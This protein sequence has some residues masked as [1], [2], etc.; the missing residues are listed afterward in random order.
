MSKR[1]FMAVILTII[2]VSGSVAQKKNADYADLKSKIQKIENDVT[3]IRRDQLNYKIEK[4]LLKEAFSSNLQTINT[5][6]VIVF[7]IFTVVGFLG[8]RDIG[9]LK[10]EYSQELEKLNRLGDDLEQKIKKIVQ[11]QE[12]D[13]S[14]YLKILNTNEEQNRRLKVLELQ[15][16]ISTLVQNRNYRMALEYIT[17][18]LDMD[19]TNLNVL[20]QKSYAQIKLRDYAGAIETNKKILSLEPNTLSAVAELLEVYLLLGSIDE[21]DKLFNENK[22]LISLRDDGNLVKYFELFRLYLKANIEDM[23]KS[24]SEFLEKQTSDKRRRSSWDFEDILVYLSTHTDNEKKRLL[25]DFIRF[26]NGQIS[27]DECTPNN[28]GIGFQSILEWSLVLPKRIKGA[29]S[30]FPDKSINCVLPPPP[31]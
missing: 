1:I 3:E 18:T 22:I 11:K 10:R 12:Q 4:D 7:G 25:I 31:E 2:F 15:G 28:G 17:V 16:K 8:V 21:F 5:V 26:L 9:T 24:V 20:S 14:D 30:F 29:G 13:E 19:P 23:K 6:L 27:K